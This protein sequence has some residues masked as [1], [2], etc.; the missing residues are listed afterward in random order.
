MT[1]EERDLIEQFIARTGGTPAASGAFGAVPSAAPAQPLPPVDPEADAFIG[2]LFTK[3][4]E[5]RYRI[6]QL[7]FVQEHAL[8]AASARI[9]ELTQ[10]LN[11]AR[12]AQQQAAPQG[13]PWGQGASA[14]P[15]PPQSRGFLSSLF[16]GAA[17]GAAAAPPPRQYAPP[18][19][20]YAPPQYAPP[21]YAPGMP[22]QMAQQSGTGFLGGALR[23][24]AGVAGGVVAG[25]ALMNLFS[26]HHDGGFGGMGGFGGQVSNP[27][28][29]IEEMPAQASPWSNPQ[30]APMGGV[31]P[32]DQGGAQKD[33]GYVDNTSW[34]DPN[35]GG[36]GGGWTDTTSAP[37][38]TSW[39]DTSSSGGD[40]GG[41]TDTSSSDDNNS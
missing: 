12:Q 36:G 8:T 39:T 5:A 30:G 15:P 23:T 28:T 34:T 31:D 13:S 3:Y 22:P 4:P 14:P 37:V 16:G 26:G 21:Q 19:P 27:T 25:E 35:Q 38:D 24:A 18:P 41:W 32:Y 10:A 6:T 17:G 2:Q 9:N 7:A 33:P 1:N 29:I 40:D 11:Q 20:Q